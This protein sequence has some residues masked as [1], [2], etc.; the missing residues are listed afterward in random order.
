MVGFVPAVE[1]RGWDETDRP[2]LF[3][4]EGQDVGTPGAVNVIFP[5]PDAQPILYLPTVDQFLAL[6]FETVCAKG[7]PALYLTVP[8]RSGIGTVASE[9]LYESGRILLDRLQL[10]VKL[11]YRPV[12]RVDHRPAMGVLTACLLLALAALSV[13]WFVPVHLVWIAAGPSAEAQTIVHL[14]TPSSLLGSRG[15]TRLAGEISEGLADES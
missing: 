14:F 3:Q 13:T 15:L 1:L 5:S 7:G 8:S 2:L 9:T 4:A 12:L 10:E 11:D 6:G